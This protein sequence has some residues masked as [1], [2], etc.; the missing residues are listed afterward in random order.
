MVWSQSK[1]HMRPNKK[2]APTGDTPPGVSLEKPVDSGSHRLDLEQARAIGAGATRCA[3]EPKGSTTQ[4]KPK[5][6]A[7]GSREPTTQS[8]TKRSGTLAP[9]SSDVGTGEKTSIV[10]R[11]SQKGRAGGQG[12]VSGS[13]AMDTRATR[14]RPCDTTPI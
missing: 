3:E 10:T 2:R 13:G 9:E 14:R 11:Q 7:A 4:A 8:S 6:K 1:R 12:T 5:G